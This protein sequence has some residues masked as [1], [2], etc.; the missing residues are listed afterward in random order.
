M[1]YK[2]DGQQFSIRIPRE[3]WDKIEKSFS[4]RNQS[5]LSKNDKILTLLQEA[6]NS[7]EMTKGGQQV[8]EGR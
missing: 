8:A 3:L 4:Y 2:G 6:L 5:H 1:P 7:A